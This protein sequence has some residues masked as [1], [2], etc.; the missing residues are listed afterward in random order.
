MIGRLKPPHQIV[1]VDV[2][3]VDEVLVLGRATGV[4]AGADHERPSR[5][6]QSLVALDRLLV[7]RRD[8]QVR[9]PRLAEQRDVADGLV[10]AR[11]ARLRVRGREPPCREWSPLLRFSLPRYARV[12]ASRV[13][14]RRTGR[15][16]RVS[17][18]EGRLCPESAYAVRRARLYSPIC[19]TDG[20]R[21]PT[22][23][24]LLNYNRRGVTA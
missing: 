8:R 9:M 10:G 12:G 24:F 20:S 17:G 23:G 2:R 21:P 4:G 6:E 14:T 19:A 13:Y 16:S 15:A 11:C 22:A 18:E 3:L 7:K 1:V 5:C